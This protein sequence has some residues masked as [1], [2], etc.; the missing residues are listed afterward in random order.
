M[1][2]VLLILRTRSLNIS[3][4][5]LR[6]EAGTN[7]IDQIG[8]FCVCEGGGGGHVDKSLKR[9]AGLRA[10]LLALV[11]YCP[12]LRYAARQHRLLPLV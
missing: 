3:R 8:Y 4:A 5:F 12:S 11:F 2:G 6:A 9:L 7:Q 1:T 10:E